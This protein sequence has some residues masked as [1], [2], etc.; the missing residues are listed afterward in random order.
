MTSRDCTFS[1]SSAEPMDLLS[2]TAAGSQHYRG[3]TN[4][5]C[6]WYGNNGHYVR[7]CTA[8]VHA[9]KADV[10]IPGIATG[11]QKK[12]S[13]RCGAPAGNAVERVDIGHAVFKTATAR[14]KMTSQALSS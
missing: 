11:K 9:A 3:S 5:R 10:T 4:V 14:R 13:S 2:A 7:E 6:F 8:S 12:A 1:F